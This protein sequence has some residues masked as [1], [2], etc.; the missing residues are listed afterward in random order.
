VHFVALCTELR[1]KSDQKGGPTD[2]QFPELFAYDQQLAWLEEDLRATSAAWKIAFFHQPLHTV[3]RY[4]CRPEFQRDL[5]RLFD[6]YGVSL[7]ISGHD[8]SYQRTWRISNATRERADRGTVQV[9]SGGAA[10]PFKRHLEA[11]WNVLHSPVLHYLR[12]EI[13]GDRL[14][15]EA[16]LDSGKVLE[17]WEMRTTGQPVPRA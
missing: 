8:H 16:V 4:P 12:M 14:R 15:G 2:S 13:D 6:R 3:G 11:D 1:Q 5:G 17:A 7:V 10:Y 9:I